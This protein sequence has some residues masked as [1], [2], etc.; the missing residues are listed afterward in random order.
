MSVTAMSPGTFLQSELRRLFDNHSFSGLF[1]FYSK[2]SCQWKV[3]PNKTCT[4]KSPITDYAPTIKTTTTTSTSTTKKSPITDYAP[5]KK[6]TTTISPTSESTTK[7]QTDIKTIT[8][9]LWP[10]TESSKY[11]PNILRKDFASHAPHWYH[12]DMFV[13]RTVRNGALGFLKI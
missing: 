7:F 4:T 13:V 8:T 11:H 3:L 9:T 12:S 6:S 10:A 2:A 5:T 1:S